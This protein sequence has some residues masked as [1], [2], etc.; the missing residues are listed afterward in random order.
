MTVATHK[1]KHNSHTHHRSISKHHLS[2]RPLKKVNREISH[3]VMK[4]PYR[5][6]GI[7]TLCVGAII[8]FMY[9]KIKFLK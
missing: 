1:P 9:A 2:L 3:Y 5:S 7:A 6:L 4:K 8:G